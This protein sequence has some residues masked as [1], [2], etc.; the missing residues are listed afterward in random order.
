MFSTVRY[1]KPNATAQIIEKALWVV[2]IGGTLLAIGI[3]LMREY[4]PQI[5]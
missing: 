2:I 1:T 5:P 4:G 3:M